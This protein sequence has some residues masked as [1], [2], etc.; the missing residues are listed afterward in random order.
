VPIL[1][2]VTVAFGTTAPE[3]SFTVPVNAPVADVWPKRTGAKD[4]EKK[5]RDKH[6]P[7]KTHLSSDKI[8]MH[9][10]LYLE[11]SLKRVKLA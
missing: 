1:K 5:T 3:E 10:L 6:V 11:V 9:L 4:I 2:A 8:F 7:A